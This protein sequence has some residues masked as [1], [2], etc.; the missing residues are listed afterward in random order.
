MHFE[1]RASALRSQ[2]L[3][4]AEAHLTTDQEPNFTLT[5]AATNVLLVAIGKEGNDA[6]ASSY[7]AQT[8]EMGVQMDLFCHGHNAK[9]RFESLTASDARAQAHTAWG[10]FCFYR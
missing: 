10:I 4:E 3:A 9:Q 6:K 5:L 8:L 2:F 7:F 1:P